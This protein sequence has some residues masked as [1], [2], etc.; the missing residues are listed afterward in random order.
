MNTAVVL[1]ATP[2]LDVRTGQRGWASTIASR[3][4]ATSARWAC[5]AISC[6]AK[7]GMTSPAASVPTTTTVC[8]S[9]GLFAI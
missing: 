6:R 8:S 9:I 4:V 1:T 3:C 2:G 7:W 5:R